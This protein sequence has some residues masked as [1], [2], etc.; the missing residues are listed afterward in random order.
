M[1]SPLQEMAIGDRKKF[2]TD[3]Q[4]T[5]RKNKTGTF[6]A[7]SDRFA[8]SRFTEDGSPA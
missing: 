1:Y 6:A 3:V 4:M 7:T 2:L 8:V 5:L